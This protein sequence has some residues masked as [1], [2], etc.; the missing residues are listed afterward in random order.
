M[1]PSTD[2][3]VCACISR[4]SDIVGFSASAVP[5][6]VTSDSRLPKS[7]H[8]RACCNMV[9]LVTLSCSVQARRSSRK[10]RPRIHVSAQNSSLW[11]PASML[12]AFLCRYDTYQNLATDPVKTRGEAE[13]H[14]SQFRLAESSTW[15]PCS[16]QLL[17]WQ[18]IIR[19]LALPSTRTPTFLASEVHLWNMADELPVRFTASLPLHLQR[20]EKH[21]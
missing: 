19:P 12:Q 3:L 5:T 11:V 21:H 9:G 4:N 14:L 1:T 13:A 7:T 6:H 16:P 18:S 10:P 15:I 8:R 2:H 20:E 17:M